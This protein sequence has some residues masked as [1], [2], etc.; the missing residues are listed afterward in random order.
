MLA[1][2]QVGAYRVLRQIGAGGMGSVWLAEHSMLGRKAAI[3][4]LH[5]SFSSRPEIVARFFNE[6]RAATATSDA[7]IVQVF[8]FGHHVDGSAYIV[9]EMLEGETLGK[10]LA[11]HGPLRLEDA[12]RLVRQVAGSLGAAHAVGIV[13]RDLKPENIF[14]VPDAEIPG[15]LRAKILDFGIAKLVGDQ[16][17]K[18]HTAAVMGTPAYMS[19]EQ[20]RGAGQVDQRS[21][22]Y[23]LGCVLF[24]LLTGAPPFEAEGVGDIIAM[25]LREAP[26]LPSSLSA[27]IPPDVDAIIL[28]CLA[29]APADRF[30]S[31]R[32][33][34]AALGPL[35]GIAAAALVRA[36]DSPPRAAVG[37]T[38]PDTTIS[39]ASGVSIV[40]ARTSGRRTA[41]V[42]GA[43]VALG[44]VIAWLAT[45]DGGP[46]APATAPAAVGSAGAV[47]VPSTAPQLTALLASFA[48]WARA[49][50]GAPCPDVFDL[51]PASA[52][53]W[54]HP[55]R[56]TC[57]DQ[58]AQQMVGAISAGPD[59][60]FGTRD[61]VTSWQLPV[62][63]TEV[64]AGPHWGAAMASAPAV[65]AVTTP[66]PTPTPTPTKPATAGGKPVVARV[67]APLV[68]DPKPVAR[69]PDP[70]EPAPL[71]FAELQKARL[72]VNGLVKD[73]H[74]AAR[75]GSCEAV[76]ALV[77]KIQ[78]LDPAAYRDRL[79]GDANLVRCVEA[80]GTP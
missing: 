74:A 59:G 27:R 56:L 32:E 28:R 38:V 67:P 46:R 9:M 57:T 72:T 55:M 76:R 26:P 44:G 47:V 21:D 37:Q 14:L 42:L 39:G 51:G 36:P 20:C 65:K 1:G 8:D 52:D 54:G 49:H 50:P 34:A 18:T 77:A 66:T 33:L 64:V 58:P 6:A 13:H 16:T 48:T 12:L 43:L 2:T 4:V 53:A 75:T 45:R 40:P 80:G 31:G 10:R 17:V 61:D 15:G 69:L 29:K 70:P 68:T 63:A 19:P 7:G 25:H 41:V 11:T 78:P 3:K 62:D 22:V 23:A 60:V 79:A 24:T 73:A 30:G 5:A 71:T 35:V